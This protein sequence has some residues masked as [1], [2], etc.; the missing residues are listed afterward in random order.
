M[1]KPTDLEDSMGWF[2]PKMKKHIAVDYAYAFWVSCRNNGHIKKKPEQQLRQPQNMMQSSSW[3]KQTSRQGFEHIHTHDKT[4]FDMQPL[5]FADWIF[6]PRSW[7]KAIIWLV[8]FPSLLLQ[9]VSPLVWNRRWSLVSTALKHCR[10][11]FQGMNQN[12]N[13]K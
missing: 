3:E 9:F 1:G 11:N 4:W 10:S 6:S 2:N 13:L 8:A 7:L 5:H 12:T